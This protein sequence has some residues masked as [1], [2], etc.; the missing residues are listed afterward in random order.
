MLYTKLKFVRM[1]TIFLLCVAA[2]QSVIAQGRGPSPVI[3]AEV[4][5]DVV[6]PTQEFVGTIVPERRAIV[7]SAVDG[8]VAEFLINEGDRVEAMEPLAQ[9]LDETISQELIAA[10]AE[11]ALREY[12]LEELETGSR[13]AEKR[14]AAAM[15]QVAEAQQDLAKRQ[16]DRV[17][18]LAQSGSAASE[19]ELDE[20]RA[21]L[22]QTIATME[23]RVAAKEL[24]DEGP[25]Q[26]R[27]LQAKARRDMQKAV[28]K[29]LS[30]QKRKHTI[31][32]RFAGYVVAERTEQGEWVNRGGPVAEI[33]ALDNVDAEVFVL[34]SYIPYV[35]RG[36]AVTVRVPSLPEVLADGR[37][38]PLDGDVMYVTPE[39]DSRSRTFPVKVRLKNALEEGV[40][41]MK[42]GMVARV[43]LPIG[44]E[45]PARLIPK[46]ALV[47]GGAKPVVWVVDVAE[48]GKGKVRP[49]PIKTGITSG[50]RIEVLDGLKVGDVIVQE[51]NERLQPGA[52]VVI[53]SDS[54]TTA[55]K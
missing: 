5:E 21:Q 15:L 12:E 35:K 26:E 18:K 24:V 23:D 49:A 22:A 33:A 16:F 51:G 11:L 8:R 37:K 53:L 52:E 46:D 6:A 42:A 47:L 17:Q 29:K 9:L 14:Q 13:P 4:V 1:E 36:A 50:T 45:K 28:V 43:T 3:V 20:A 30:D 41:V 44:P 32:S 19:D 7:G 2:T 10:E 40:P 25:R 39:A 54:E 34:E 38:Q 48:K 31:I 27:I 55:S